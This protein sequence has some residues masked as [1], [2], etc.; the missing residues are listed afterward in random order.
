K[1]SNAPKFFKALSQLFIADVWCRSQPENVATM[2]AEDVPRS[3]HSDQLFGTIRPNGEK[4]RAS[5]CRH[6]HHF[7]E[8][9]IEIERFETVLQEAD[10]TTADLA[11]ALRAEAPSLMNTEYGSRSI[12]CRRIVGGAGEA[13]CALS[14]HHTAGYG[15][16]L[17]RRKFTEPSGD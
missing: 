10:L 11:Q 17:E 16:V 14:I 3:K 9:G 4:P 8:A 7:G 2:I 6:G 12:M 15:L 13:R 5:F 1:A